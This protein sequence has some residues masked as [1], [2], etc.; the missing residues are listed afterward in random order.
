MF[1]H[2]SPIRSMFFITWS[3][4]EIR[5]R[6]VATG[7]CVK[8]SQDR[9]VDLE[10]APVDPVVVGDNELR[11]LDVL[12]LRGLDRAIEG[13]DDEIEPVECLLLE[14]LELLLVTDSGGL[15]WHGAAS[16]PSRSRSPPSAGRT[17]W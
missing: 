14:L 16:P 6:S 5:R 13:L 2:W 7:A 10:V 12:V 15:V 1:T 3:S 11:E 8:A 4:A 17:G 9:L